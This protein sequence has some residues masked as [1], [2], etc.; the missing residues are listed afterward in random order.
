M[1]N[2]TFSSYTDWPDL[3][4]AGTVHSLMNIPAEQA[5]PINSVTAP[6]FAG[7]I[8][9][10]ACP[11]RNSFVL[12]HSRDLHTDV[13][14]IRNFGAAG[15]VTL[16]EDE[17]FDHL[18]IR[19]LPSV[20][21]A[22]GLWWRHLPIRDMGAPNRTFE[23]QWS[24]DGPFLREALRAGDKL[25]LHCWAG[26]GR[27]GTIAAKLLV[28]FGVDPEEAIRQVRTARP[29]A[30]QSI[31]QERYIMRCKPVLDTANG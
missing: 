6:A 31:A 26:L 22:A 21:T 27:T 10:C 17:E 16:V 11:G 23:R 7:A 13:Q 5:L 1:V 30:I 25:V 4:C 28:E 2:R 20:L 14:R 18:G 8:G 29:G 19:E 24:I 12:S 3:I 9:M 15:I